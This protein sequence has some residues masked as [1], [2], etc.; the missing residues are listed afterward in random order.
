MIQTEST[1]LKVLLDRSGLKHV[2]MAHDDLILSSDTSAHNLLIPSP[3]SPPITSFCWLEE[4]EEVKMKKPIYQLNTSF[5]NSDKWLT[6]WLGFCCILDPFCH[7]VLERGVGF[8]GLLFEVEMLCS[9][10]QVLLVALFS[11]VLLAQ[12][13]GTPRRDT[14]TEMLRADL[15]NDKVGNWN[16]TL[17]FKKLKLGKEGDVISSNYYY[18]IVLL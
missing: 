11:S 14:L 8:L 6:D 1:I 15:S 9:Q 7:R 17:R 12:V 4:E 16:I 13:S 2:A 5:A 10:V 3:S 18:L